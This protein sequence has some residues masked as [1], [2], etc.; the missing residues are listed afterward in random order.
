MDDVHLALLGGFECLCAGTRVALPLGAQ[1]LVALLALDKHGMRRATA[2]ELLWPDSTRGRAAANLRSALWRGK[3]VG[4]MTVIDCAGP[5]LRLASAV[6]VDL[7]ELSFRVRDI[8]NPTYHVPAINGWR[9]LVDDLTRELLPDW[10]EDWLLYERERWDQLRI[11]ALEGIGQQLKSE[12]YYLAALQTALATITIEPTRETAH[13]LLIE[14]YIAEGNFASAL[15]HYQRYRRQLQR[16]LGL[17]PSQQMDQLV[18]PL[19]SS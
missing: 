18:R 4:D 15:K 11:H 2:G 5:R 8:A 3:R 6:S 7:H 1:R 10:S 9:G 13:R 16:E 19:M 17:A 14:V 12:A